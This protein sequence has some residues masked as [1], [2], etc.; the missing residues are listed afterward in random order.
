MSQ[1]DLTTVGLYMQEQEYLKAMHIYE[2]CIAED[3]TN[4]LCID[5]A[6]VA[7]F[8]SGILY[9]AKRHFHL[10]E[11]DPKYFKN[12]YIHLANI[13]ELEEHIPKAIN[14]N[15][16][17]RD[18]FP[19]N[20]LYYRKMAQLY[21]KAQL[22]FEALS[23]YQEAYNLNPQDLISL[24]ALIDLLVQSAQHQM[25]DSLLGLGFAIDHES[26]QLNQLKAKN[27]YKQRMYDSTV[28]V[29][30]TIY[31]KIDFTNYYN[32]MMGY[33]LIQIDSIDKAIFFLE[34]SLVNEGDPEYA[35]YY[36]GI[37]YEKQGDIQ[38][39]VYH[40]NQAI[41]AGKS[42][43]L[44]LY[45]KNLGRIHAENNQW[46]ESL[47]AYEWSYRYDPESILLY[48]MGEAAEKYYKDKSIAINYY[49][50]YIRSNDLREDVKK[51]SKDKV[52]YLREWQH[53][54]MNK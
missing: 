54:T 44:P 39:S 34:R 53:S 11:K 17:L 2:E 26:I 12:A 5:Q 48:F 9:K 6:G 4:L 18:S 3:S 21:M 43:G 15:R 49:E 40:F 41:D 36:L 33:S 14:Y 30:Q 8:R 37:A 46:K 20:A 10:L 28:N 31:Q 23:H 47:S 27:F 19:E 32:K 22:P 16:L 29:L 13:Y 52:R 35:H 38:A 50:R 1:S 45:Y 51:Y 7:A 24:G 42:S 25:A